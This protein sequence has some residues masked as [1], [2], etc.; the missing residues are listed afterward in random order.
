MAKL[1]AGMVVYADNFYQGLTKFVISRTTEKQAVVER[2]KPQPPIKFYR[3]IYTYDQVRIVGGQSYDRV[4]YRVETEDLKCRYLKQCLTRKFEK[5]DVK[6]L[7]VEQ[8][9]AIVN[10]AFP[11]RSGDLVA[12]TDRQKEESENGA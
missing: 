6:T 1:E 8:L 3:E 12:D 4:I 9:K 11:A 2:M 5:I 10:V 7:T